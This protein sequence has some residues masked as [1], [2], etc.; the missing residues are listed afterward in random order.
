MFDAHYTRIYKTCEKPACLNPLHISSKKPENQKKKQKPA[1]PRS[2]KLVSHSYA[3]AWKNL[4][5]QLWPEYL[6]KLA[7]L[8]NENEP[9][10]AE[11]QKTSYEVPQVEQKPLKAGKLK[12]NF[13]VNT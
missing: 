12:D 7:A 3:G 9:V 4:D 11:K 2:K 5:A 13:Y 8:S 1:N 10:V 6:E